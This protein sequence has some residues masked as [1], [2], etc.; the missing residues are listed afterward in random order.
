MA[1]YTAVRTG[2]CAGQCLDGAML[3]CP[4]RIFWACC[5]CFPCYC[6]C[7]TATSPHI[8]QAS[9]R[10]GSG[11]VYSCCVRR[12]REL[13]G[14]ES[15]IPCDVTVTD[16][17]I[18]SAPYLI[19]A[20]R[21]SV[22]SPLWRF[23]QIRRSK[24]IPISRWRALPPSFLL[25]LTFLRPLA[26]SKADGLGDCSALHSAVAVSHGSPSGAPAE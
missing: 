26:I 20:R 6:Y 11:C 24:P 18:R 19:S 3:T 7:T 9:C 2:L 16:G 13:L 15:A 1:L 25:I 22:L 10:R 5:H 23:C 4:E 12:Y 17:G 14:I 8:E 21:S